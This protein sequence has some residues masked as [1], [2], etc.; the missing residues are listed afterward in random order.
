MF[1]AQNKYTHINVNTFSIYH[2]STK[3]NEPKKYGWHFPEV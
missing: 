3:Q 1:F 2:L